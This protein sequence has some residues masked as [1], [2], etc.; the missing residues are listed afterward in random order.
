MIS[1]PK[2]ANFLAG[3][4]GSGSGYGGGWDSVQRFDHGSVG[5]GCS[6][7]WEPTQ[8]L[9]E[10]KACLPP[11]CPRCRSQN[12]SW[13]R[14]GAGVG[15]SLTLSPSLCRG[16]VARLLRVVPAGPAS[17]PW[18]SASSFALLLSPSEKPRIFLGVG[19][20]GV[21]AVRV[22]VGGNAGTLR[23]PPSLGHQTR[24]TCS[25]LFSSELLEVFLRVHFRPP[26]PPPPHA[27]SQGNS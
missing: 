27:H 20:A 18:A 12:F 9:P 11:S 22:L 19:G 14:R 15:T 26:P 3:S 21:F 16:F 1:I 25:S 7:H 6:G 8:A 13:G 4:G 5:S 17:K 2:E 23:P 10:E 24:A